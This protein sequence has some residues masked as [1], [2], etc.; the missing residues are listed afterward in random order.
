V[1]F[2]AVI[3]GGGLQGG[4][5][6]LA[7]LARRNGT[8]IALIERGPALGGNH[9]WC[10][11]R[12]DVPDEARR[13]LDP[14]VIASWPEHE[15]AFPRRR[16]VL[17]SVY[18]AMTSARLDEVVRAR[19]EAAAGCR[20]LL[21]SEVTAVESGAA[22]VASGERIEGRLV[23]DARGPE[24]VRPGARTAYQKFFGLE[25]T[26]GRDLERPVLMDATVPQ[27]DG[28]RFLYLLPLGRGRVLAEETFF[29][30]APGLDR[31]ALRASVLGLLDARGLEPREV[32]REEE[33]ELPLPWEPLHAP[34]PAGGP[35]VAGVRGG[36]YHPATGYSL[37]PAA[38]L[39]LAVAAAP[40]P[41]AA[42][43]AVVELGRA[44][45]RQAAF[46]RLLN[47]FVFAGWPPGEWYRVFE[48]FYRLPP[49]CIARFY[50]LE[51]TATDRARIL[52]G[53]PPPG[54]SLHRAVLG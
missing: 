15:V 47:R 36:F 43:A 44:H 20:L 31:A 41:A 46:A 30:P 38:R 32:V 34:Q 12:G 27:R 24:P 2:D 3:V 25:V 39:A 49:G 54:L 50:A 11:Q 53:I 16:R 35:L 23:V 21:S 9:T 4:L 26:A 37:G 51:T 14:L 8:Q 33:G 7:L 48:W 22:I 5:L 13:W 18:A 28:M 19:L 40:T 42:L 6:A 17:R 1:G 45:E 10:F 29:S 52:L